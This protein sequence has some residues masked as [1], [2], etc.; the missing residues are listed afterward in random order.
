MGNQQYQAST[1]IMEVTSVV[2]FPRVQ[3]VTTMRVVNRR[4]IASPPIPLLGDGVVRLLGV[5]ETTLGE[6]TATGEP[7]GRKI[8]GEADAPGG[9]TMTPGI[10]A[11]TT[12]AKTRTR[13]TETGAG[14]LGPRRHGAKTDPTVIADG[15]ATVADEIDEEV[16]ILDAKTELP[17]QMVETGDILGAIHPG[18][19][20]I[21]SL[22]GAGGGT[23]LRLREAMVEFEK[24]SQVSWGQPAFRET[25]G[26]Q[27]LR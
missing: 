5:I 2:K 24:R 13:K 22:C 25:Y 11:G 23:M 17:R 6:M 14:T 10:V 18:D 15:V 20:T 3:A 26:A 27:L 1:L 16:A 7:S 4:T 8:A 19:V 21:V 12:M 9:A